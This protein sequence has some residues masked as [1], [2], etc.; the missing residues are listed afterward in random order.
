M[1]AYAATVLIDLAIN[2]FDASVPDMMSLARAAESNDAGCIW[3]ADHFSGAVVGRS[4]S[5]DPF[6]CLGAIAAVTEQI[7]VGVLVANVVNRH[8]AQLAS[9]VNSL[10]SIA[11]GRVRLG[12]GSG[13]APGSRF[14]VEHEAIGTVLGDAAARRR[15]LVDTISSLRAIWNDADGDGDDVGSQRSAAVVDS[16]PCPPIVVGASAWPTV[17]IALEVADGVN[18]RRT[19]ALD[20]LLGRIGR[21]RPVDFEVSVLDSLDDVADAPARIERYEGLGVDRLIL[22]ISPPHDVARLDRVDLRRH[23]A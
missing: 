19:G 14:A 10:Q 20:E 3:V 12:V 8:P 13:A 23:R 5:R 1:Q 6:V 15:R 11:A 16:S 9:A 4:W 7:E 21:E 18:V 2:P 17:E 22:G